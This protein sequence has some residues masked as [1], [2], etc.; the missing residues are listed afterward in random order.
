MS[1][2]QLKYLKVCVASLSVRNMQ[3]NSARSSPAEPDLWNGPM[4]VT[5]N[6]EHSEYF[7][8]QL[9]KSETIYTIMVNVGFVHLIRQHVDNFI[10][11]IRL[12]KLRR[13][14]IIHE[15]KQKNLNTI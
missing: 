3:I 9:Q 5:L 6:Y 8:V 11:F 10:S 7:L 14:N 2:Y 4:L 13:K 15:Q 1:E 12:W